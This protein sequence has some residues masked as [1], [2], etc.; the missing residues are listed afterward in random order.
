LNWQW[1]DARASLHRALERNPSDELVMAHLGTLSNVLGEFEE[2]RRYYEKA[3]QLDPIAATNLEPPAY[4]LI[5]TGKYKEARQQLMRAIKLAPASILFVDLCVID[6]QEGNLTL[7]LE[8]AEK[9]TDAFWRAFAQS[10]VLWQQ[11]SVKEANAKLDFIV[12]NYPIRA[13]KIAELYAYRG[14]NENA[15]R[16]L[17]QACNQHDPA[18]SQINISPFFR[19]IHND[20]RFAATL[21]RMGLEMNVLIQ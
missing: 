12:K 13:F 17:N 19:G 11:Q 3:I 18:L 4:L 2:A 15:F 20:P 9:C 6:L 16:W 1:E 7:A 10:L 8:H 5:C 14:E 21:K